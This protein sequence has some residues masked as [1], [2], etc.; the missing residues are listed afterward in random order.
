MP[1][2]ACRFVLRGNDKTDKTVGPC[3]IARNCLT[4]HLPLRFAGTRYTD[5]NLSFVSIKL[6]CASRWEKIICC[7]NSKYKYRILG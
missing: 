4:H 7:K 1:G 5:H 6:T 2:C 3:S